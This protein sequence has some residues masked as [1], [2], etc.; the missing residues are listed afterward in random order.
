M[1]KIIIL[2]LVLLLNNANICA[3]GFWNHVQDT[4]TSPFAISVY[5]VVAAGAGTYAAKQI[6]DPVF[7]I[8]KYKTNLLS[9]QEKHL[10]LTL[11]KEDAAFTKQEFEINAAKRTILTNEFPDHKEDVEKEIEE[12]KKSD[13]PD[14]EKQEKI[15]QL[16]K[17]LAN[18]ERKLRLVRI[19]GYNQMM[20]ATTF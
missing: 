7:Y 15:N 12:I 20:K 8:I 17:D 3:E 13:L 11:R 5:K 9:P 18:A 4:F 6:M 1:H 16:Q 19:L 2:T 14:S 10:L